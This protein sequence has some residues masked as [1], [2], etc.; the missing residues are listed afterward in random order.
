VTFAAGGALMAGAALRWWLRPAPAAEPK[1]SALAGP[2][3]GM[4][5]YTTR[6]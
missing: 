5:F 3:G 6:F 1:V 4:V 2:S